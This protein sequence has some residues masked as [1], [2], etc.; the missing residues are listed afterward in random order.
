MRHE[1]EHVEQIARLASFLRLADTGWVGT[2][3]EQ[4]GDLRLE[5]LEQRVGG[6]LGLERGVV[7]VVDRLR[8]A[9]WRVVSGEDGENRA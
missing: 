6:V 5:P 4:R 1:R 9:A 2:A 3:P 7:R 8:R